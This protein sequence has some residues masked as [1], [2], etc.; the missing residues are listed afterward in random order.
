MSAEIN[1]PRLTV[2]T[3]LA[4]IGMSKIK[5]MEEF[6]MAEQA[7]IVTGIGKAELHRIL[8]RGYDLNKDLVGKITFTD[9]TSLILRGRLPTANEARMLDALMVI[10]VEHGMISHVVAARLLYHCAPEAMQGAVAAALC[11]AGSVHLGSSEWSAK[12]LLDALPTDTQNPEYDAIATKIIDDYTA[13]K[14]R[15]PGIGHRTH[16]E[17]DPRAETLFN[18][19]K[20]TGVYGKYCELIQRLSKLSSERRKRLIPVNVTGAIA[21]IAL[22]MGFTWQITKAFALIGRTLGAI[23][24]IAEEIQN[25]MAPQ[26]DL[27]IKQA[28]VYEPVRT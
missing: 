22:D 7:K 5:L 6:P 15:M 17:G 4:Y 24:H 23:G 28:L 12:M 13:R 18:I 9:M 21:A 26:I 10:L 25:P 14:Q 1:Q 2:A 3:R 11:G 19:A 8:V 27:A 16:A 20:D